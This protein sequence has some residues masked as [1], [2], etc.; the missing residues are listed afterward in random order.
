MPRDSEGGGTRRLG[1][2]RKVAEGVCGASMFH[3]DWPYGA[4]G[5]IE[6]RYQELDRQSKEGWFPQKNEEVEIPLVAGG[7]RKQ[8]RKTSIDSITST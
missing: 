8:S 6:G 4:A 5:G 7:R 3:I 2:I 1:P